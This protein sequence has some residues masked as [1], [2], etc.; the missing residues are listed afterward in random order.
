MKVSHDHAFTEG[1]D[2]VNSLTS[3]LV[4]THVDEDEE[5]SETHYAIIE[6]VAFVIPLNSDVTDPLTAA[7]CRDCDMG[8]AIK[9]APP[10]TRGRTHQFIGQIPQK[11]RTRSCKGAHSTQGRF[12]VSRTIAVAGS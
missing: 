9:R 1:I 10:V 7:I 12:R 2:N 11:Q 3:V 5:E 6:D 8:L 4:S